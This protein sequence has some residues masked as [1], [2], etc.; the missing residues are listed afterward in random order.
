MSD[1]HIRIVETREQAHDAATQVYVMA[2][3]LIQ[4]GK[5]VQIA[6]GEDADPISL[7]Q[8][9]FLHG[10]VF[11]QISEQVRVGGERYVMDVWKEFFRKMLLPD[12]Y[13]MRRIPVYDKKQCRLVQ[14]K[15]ATPYRV[16]SSTED[17]GVK[18]YS[19][20]IEKVIA[21]A[22]TEWGVEF[23]FD[24]RERDAVRYVPHQ[25]KRKI[26]AETGEILEPA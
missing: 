2:K 10:P 25:T 22:V 13:E 17:L 14:P 4:D 15:R 21:Y 9:R 6:V 11:S 23:Q 12:R 16:R 19:E 7:K 24:Q 3:A 26:N 18:K 20:Y 1:R 8:R 5:R